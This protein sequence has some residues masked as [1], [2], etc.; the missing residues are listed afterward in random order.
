MIIAHRG[1]SDDAPENTLSSVRLAWEQDADA[2]EVD[3]RM[4]SD[5]RIVL[6]HD[7]DAG[8]TGGV[9]KAVA[10]MTLS[11]IRELDVGAWKGAR[12]AGERVPEL[13][14]VLAVVPG[15]RVLFVEIKCGVEIVAPLG[16]ALSKAGFSGD[17]AA[18]VSFRPRVLK[19]VVR[20][21]K[22]IPVYLL[23]NIGPALP[24]SYWEPTVDEMVHVARD[25]GAKGLS[26]RDRPVVDR[27]FASRVHDEGL[28]CLTWTVDDPDRAKQLREAGADGIVTNRPGAI[29]SATV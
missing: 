24:P 17:R 14:E 4:T 1:A 10:N 25:I 11:E 8:R 2:A 12:W 21:M 18:I 26:V 23:V 29:R 6:M 16:D 13:D 27:A 7:E 22:D 19:K 15:G 9:E 3:V 5:R 20:T 28:R